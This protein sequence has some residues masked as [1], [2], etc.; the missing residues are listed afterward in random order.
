MEIALTLCHVPRILHMLLGF[1]HLIFKTNLSLKILSLSTFY[2]LGSKGRV[3]RVELATK[4]LRFKFPAVVADFGDPCKYVRSPVSPQSSCC[5]PA[6]RQRLLCAPL[7]DF[8][9]RTL[10]RGRRKR[11]HSCDLVSKAPTQKRHTLLLSTCLPK[12]VT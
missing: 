9:S 11:I 12:Q 7:K 6:V 4:T 8:L 5:K 10:S 1:I 3:A 2:S